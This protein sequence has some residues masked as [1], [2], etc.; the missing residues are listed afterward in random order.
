MTTATILDERGL[1]ATL[2]ALGN[3]IRIQMLR[4]IA[5]HPGCICTQL[6]LATGKAQPTVSQHL[7][8]L[9]NAGL[10]EAEND[11]AATCYCLN[12]GRLTWIE[13]EVGHMHGG[14]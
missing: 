6:V 3:P 7:R 8:V 4:Y 13:R 9:R 14:R 1:A 12:E 2:K 10:V 5:Q 11:G